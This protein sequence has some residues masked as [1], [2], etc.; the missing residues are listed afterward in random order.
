MKHAF[1]AVL[2]VA[3]AAPLL[4]AAESANEQYLKIGESCA[5]AR[6]A[7][8]CMESYGFSCNQ[9]RQ[10]HRSI[11]AQHLGCNLDLGDGRYRFV[12]MLYDDGGW[13]V[14]VENTYVAEY[15]EPRWPREDSSL[16]LSSHIEQKM[17]QYRM[18]SS[19]SR[20]IARGQPTVFFQVRGAL[21]PGSPLARRA[22]QPSERNR[23]KT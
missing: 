10:P 21:M 4:C 5:K 16:A 13:N 20:S 9:S 6:E 19:G 14:E 12:Q 23:T 15:D 1:S 11:E 7:R 17:D 2:L 8:L 3:A 22:A 18:H